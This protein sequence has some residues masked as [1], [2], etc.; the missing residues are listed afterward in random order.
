MSRKHVVAYY[1]A[2]EEQYFELLR[3]TK[4]MDE[5]VK[6]GFL[7]EDRMNVFMNCV[8][9]LK[10]NYTRLSYIMYLLD[11]P[12]KPSKEKRNARSR[13]SLNKSFQQLNST[14]EQVVNENRDVLTAFKRYCKDIVETEKKSTTKEDSNNGK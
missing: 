7:P 12:N 9:K 4:D 6:N 14:Q 11:L 1:K 13:E 10:S 8:D 3:E 5:A 2:M